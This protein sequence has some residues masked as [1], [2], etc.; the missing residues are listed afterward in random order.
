MK[1]AGETG[2]YSYSDQIETVAT[3][4]WVYLEKEFEV[5]TDV[6]QLNMRV[7][8]N[9]GGTVWFDDLRICPS[10]AQMTTYTYRPLVG[11]TSMTDAKGLTTYYG[12]DGFQ[13][14]K[15]IKDREGNILKNYNYHYKDQP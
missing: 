12:Y 6:V 7:D 9:G 5:P 10:D 8:N 14:L 15:T 4:E 11:M 2:Y 13:R 3:G 1:R